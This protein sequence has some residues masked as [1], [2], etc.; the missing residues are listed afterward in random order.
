[1]PVQVGLLLCDRGRIRRRVRVRSSSGRGSTRTI[2]ADCVRRRGPWRGTRGARGR[3]GGRASAGRP[4]LGGPPSVGPLVGGPPC[5]GQS[6]GPPAAGR[7]EGRDAGLSEGHA[8]GPCA[9]PCEGP[10]GHHAVGSPC[11]L[12][13]N[14]GRGGPFLQ[15]DLCGLVGLVACRD[16]LPVAFRGDRAGLSPLADLGDP[17]DPAAACLCD[18]AGPWG[19]LFCLW[20]PSAGRHALAVPLSFL[21]GPLCV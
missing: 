7:T 15:E 4:G 9:D 6:A 14:E 12:D 18:L 3:R 19:T 16:G 5:A 17:V 11:A 10:S 2:S 8:D 20:G 21:G 13:D 1:M